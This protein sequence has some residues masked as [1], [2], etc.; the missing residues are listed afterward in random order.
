MNIEFIGAG[1]WAPGLHS[2]SD[3][4][5][6][7]DNNFSVLE[8]SVFENPKPS[9]I[10]AKE[11]RRSGLIINLAVEVAHQACAHAKIDPST[12]PSVFTSAI[13][14]TQV[15]DYMCHKLTQVEKMLSPTKF[16]NSVHNA[17]SGYWSISADN[18][19]PSTFV[20]SFLESFGASLLEAA[21]QADTY[22]HPILLVSY[23]IH[24]TPPFHDIAAVTNS[25]GI[26]FVIQPST[27]NT[28][29]KTYSKYRS[30]NASSLSIKSSLKLVKN[31]EKDKIN[32]CHSKVL[33]EYSKTN[34]I[35]GAL[36]LLEKLALRQQD[37]SIEK[38]FY[39]P[40]NPHTNIEI[41]I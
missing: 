40:I 18:R 37:K 14:D 15:T 39:L 38:Y 33:D 10:P 20:S 21:S 19:A 7:M 41:T 27:D 34:S 17:P 29:T 30:E 3:F 26:A 1:I 4:V 28:E 16:H 13:G 5:A 32:T 11:R 24:N 23:D 35:G 6:A 12:T 25:M 22:Q 31:N 2:Y 9:A 8:S 36:V